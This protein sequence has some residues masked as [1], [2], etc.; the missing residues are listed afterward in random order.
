[1]SGQQ[2]ITAAPT[3]ITNPKTAL[4]LDLIIQGLK[5]SVAMVTESGKLVPDLAGALTGF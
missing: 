3:S 5:E 1:V 4:H 2:L